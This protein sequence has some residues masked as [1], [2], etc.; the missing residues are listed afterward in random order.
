[1]ERGWND[2]R[3]WCLVSLAEIALYSS[4]TSSCGNAVDVVNAFGAVG[5]GGVAMNFHV[6]NWVSGST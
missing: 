6:V 4:E 1:M 2:G 5:V 3:T